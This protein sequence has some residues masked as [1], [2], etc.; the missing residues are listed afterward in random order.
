MFRFEHPEFFVAFLAI[1]VLLAVYFAM[2]WLQKR[3][4]KSFA[5]HKAWERLTHHWSKGRERTRAILLIASFTLLCFALANPQWG[6]RSETV[7]SKAADIF[8]A[9]DISN[10]MLARDIAPS[11]LEKAK[12]FAQELVDAFKG[13]RIGLIIFAGNAYLQ[14]PLTTDYASAELF[15]RSAHP[16]LATSQGTAIGD[17][18]ELAMR[19]YEED[20]PHH[21]ALFLITD[22]ENHEDGAIEQMQK[23]REVGLIPFVISVGT[24]E[25]DFIPIEVQGREDFKRDENG[26]PVRTAVNEAFLRQLASEGDGQLYSILDG[27]KV[28]EDMKLKM[29]GLEKR[30]MQQRAFKDYKS[31]YQ[32]FLLAAILLF[33]AERIIGNR[34]RGEQEQ[35]TA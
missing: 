2:R 17:A 14:M 27:D 5:T 6:L 19:A 23:G 26:N 4:S 7:M 8:I 11:R 15:I 18:I 3:S 35:A 33:F 20:A 25:G 29:Q 13:D 34:R 31:Y 32:F 9:L 22:G 16:R 24:T 10:S 12:R 1:P 28:I 21:K 30:E